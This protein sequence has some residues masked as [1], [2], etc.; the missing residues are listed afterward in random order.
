M[1]RN[2]FW[3][4]FHARISCTLGGIYLPSLKES[5]IDW[6]WSQD[7]MMLNALTPA[8]VV[9][10]LIISQL[11]TLLIYHVTLWYLIFKAC[12]SLYIKSKVYKLWDPIQKCQA[13]QSY[14][15]IYGFSLHISFGIYHGLPSYFCRCT[16]GK[17][18]Q[19]AWQW[20]TF[21]CNI[22]HWFIHQAEDTFDNEAQSRIT[23][24]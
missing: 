23:L 21:Y 24:F 7:V 12:F 20:M 15:G 8:P 1:A 6:H 2:H 4:A 10:T 5:H 22:Y 18:R 3:K 14:S 11:G 9:L 17:V 19:I 16:S 13:Y